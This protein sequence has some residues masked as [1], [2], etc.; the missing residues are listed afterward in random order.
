ML[1]FFIISTKSILS[2][3]NDQIFSLQTPLTKK[4][5]ENVPTPSAGFT[6][7]S[8]VTIANKSASLIKNKPI[9]DH[10]SRLISHYCTVEYSDVQSRCLLQ[11]IRLASNKYLPNRCYR[12]TMRFKMAEQKI[13]VMLFS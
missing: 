10:K 7:R 8:S 11:F 4:K 9:T 6:V 12:F 2:Q 3:K 13:Y 5:E 1:Y